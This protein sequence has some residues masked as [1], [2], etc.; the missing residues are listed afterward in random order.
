MWWRF[1]NFFRS[2]FEKKDTQENEKISNTITI[3]SQFRKSLSFDD[4]VKELN[5]TKT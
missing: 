4:L 3:P 1:R 5:S 2:F